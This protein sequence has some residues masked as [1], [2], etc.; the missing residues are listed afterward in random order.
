MGQHSRPTRREFLQIAAL[1]GAMVTPAKALTRGDEKPEPR[2]IIY[3]TLGRTGLKLPIVSMGSCYAVNL[4]QAALREGIV[5]FHSSGAYAEGEHERLLGKALNPFPRDSFVVGTAADVPY[6]RPKGG[7]PT[8]DVGT[9][10]DPRRIV[11]SLDDSL[12]RLKLDYI[13]IYY[14]AS[15]GTRDPVFHEPYLEAFDKLKR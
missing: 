2:K 7:G 12:K 11:E 9:G 14:L 3:R 8:L 15:V 10:V 4:V 5:Y 1:A 6:R 13:D